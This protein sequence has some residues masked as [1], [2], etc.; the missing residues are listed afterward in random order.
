[1]FLT[2]F[3]FIYRKKKFKKKNNNKD[4]FFLNFL[5]NDFLKNKKNQYTKNFKVKILGKFFI[6]N[7]DDD[8]Q[9]NYKDFTSFF[10]H[11]KKQFYKE[12][13]YRFDF[14]RRSTYF[15]GFEM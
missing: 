7:E 10:T 12:K 8:E 5:K 15:P 3:S 2:K 14:S 9:E 4:F 13:K 11:M 6:I 1:M